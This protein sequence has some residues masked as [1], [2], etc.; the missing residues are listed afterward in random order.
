M[1][2]PMTVIII[3]AELGWNLGIKNK[4]NLEHYKLYEIGSLSI[5]LS[6]A[7]RSTYKNKRI[8]STWYNSTGLRHK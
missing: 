4:L 5:S 2:W 6:G 8:N 1:Y 3:I 7:R